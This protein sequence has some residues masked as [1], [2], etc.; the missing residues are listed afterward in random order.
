MQPEV[1][2]K[3]LWPFRVFHLIGKQAF[4]LELP[5]KWRIH[6]VFYVSLLEQYTTMKRR[7]NDENVELDASVKNEEYQVEVI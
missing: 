2:G 7:M 5:K 6:D 3:V 4:K 1:G